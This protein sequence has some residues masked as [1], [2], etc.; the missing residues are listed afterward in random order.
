MHHCNLFHRDGLFHVQAAPG[1]QSRYSTGI[2][3]STRYADHFRRR[4]YAPADRDHHTG[5]QVQDELWEG[6]EG[7]AAEGA[8]CQWR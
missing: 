7:K 1:V 8:L 5:F 4:D 3:A 2:P 6:F